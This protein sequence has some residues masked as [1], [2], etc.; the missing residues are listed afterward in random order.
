MNRKFLKIFTLVLFTAFCIGC[1][2]DNVTGGGTAT[3]LKGSRYNPEN[4]VYS[5]SSG[6]TSNNITVTN[7][8]DGTL[9]IKGK[10]SPSSG[11]TAK[12]IDI[13]VLGWESSSSSGNSMEYSLSK[14]EN[15]QSTEAV[16]SI[17]ITLK[18]IQSMGTE[19]TEIIISI[20]YSGSHIHYSGNYSK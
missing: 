16:S 11:G 7:N 12:D 15:I 4:G 6:T 2:N 5:S 19:K 1:Q 18:K 8:A 9:Q 14:V 10:I 13:T 20:E 3:L 17:R